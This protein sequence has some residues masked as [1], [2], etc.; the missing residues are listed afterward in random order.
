VYYRDLLQ[1][2]GMGKE[3]RLHT[4]AQRRGRYRPTQLHAWR[5]PVCGF[6]KFYRSAVAIRL[7]LRCYE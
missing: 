7:T 2:T 3:S 4:E 6:G 5:Q 1:T